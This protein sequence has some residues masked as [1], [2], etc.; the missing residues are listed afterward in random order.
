MLGHDKNDLLGSEVEKSLP[1]DKQ[2][3]HLALRQKF[4]QN[5]QSRKMG[6]GRELEALRKDGKTI[7]VEIGLNPYTDRGRMLALV[8]VIDLSKR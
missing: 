3:G 1:V 8:N 6:E 7:P 4:M 5:P 2:Q